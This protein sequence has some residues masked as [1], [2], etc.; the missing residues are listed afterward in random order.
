MTL[1]ADYDY[2]ANNGVLPGF[3]Q[4]SEILVEA[5]EVLRPTIDLSPVECATE[6]R[7]I[8]GL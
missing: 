8:N 6:Y 2:Y 4:P 5:L 1:N 7:K 3:V